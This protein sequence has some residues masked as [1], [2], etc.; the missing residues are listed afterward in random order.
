MRYIIVAGTQEDVEERV[1]ARL[2]KGWEVSGSL[3]M[4]TVPDYRS[5]LDMLWYAQAMISY[6]EELPNKKGE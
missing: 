1:T 2:R 4:L 3:R 5:T 6:K